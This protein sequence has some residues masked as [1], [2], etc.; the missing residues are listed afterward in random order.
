M[1]QPK[2]ADEDEAKAF[3]KI[4]DESA[5]DDDTQRMPTLSAQEIERLLKEKNG[6]K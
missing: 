3:E 4:T 1:T 5:S 2:R 6:E